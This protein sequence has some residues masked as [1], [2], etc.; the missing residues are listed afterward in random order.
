MS[1]GNYVFTNNLIHRNLP[2]FKSTTMEKKRL[3]KNK[4]NIGQLEVNPYQKVV[5]QPTSYIDKIK[6]YL[7]LTSSRESDLDNR[8]MLRELLDHL[9]ELEGNKQ[10]LPMSEI[11]ERLTIPASLTNSP[12]S[13]MLINP[14]IIRGEHTEDISTPEIEYPKL[15]STIKPEEEEFELTEKE[16]NY[17]PE[18]ILNEL[19]ALKNKIMINQNKRATAESLGNSN[20]ISK[21]EKLIIKDGSKFDSFKSLY[22]NKT[23]TE[24]NLEYDYNY[25]KED[26]HNIGKQ[27]MEKQ[28]ELNKLMN[29]PHR[30]GYVKAKKDLDKEIEDLKFDEDE[31]REYLRNKGIP[32]EGD[33]IENTH[34]KPRKRKDPRPLAKKIFNRDKKLLANL[35]KLLAADKKDLEKA[36]GIYGKGIYGAGIGAGFFSSLGNIFKNIFGKLTGF[37]GNIFSRPNEI[38]KV[39]GTIANTVGGVKDVINAIKDKKPIGEVISNIGNVAQNAKPIQEII[40]QNLKDKMTPN[41]IKD[42]YI[43]NNPAS[44]SGGNVLIDKYLKNTKAKMNSSSLSFKNLTKGSSIH[45]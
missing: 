18:I 22:R 14:K 13:E 11:K 3:V 36:K 15:K 16:K 10:V 44:A 2:T 39:V 21:Y 17:S 24:P 20:E 42:E 7:M 37:I 40:T 30:I 5:S 19:I 35:N 9:T 4:K 33:G 8:E 34:L 6:K 23:D 43:R 27:I 1:S 32:E 45:S 29:S 28:K 41:E 25:T 38:Q 26:L 31:I 12:K